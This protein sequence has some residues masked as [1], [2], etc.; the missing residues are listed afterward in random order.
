MC[1]FERA[2]VDASISADAGA[3]HDVP[4]R[5]VEHRLFFWV[6][7]LDFYIMGATHAPRPA[8]MDG[9]PNLD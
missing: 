7:L 5:R 4:Y 9:R 2:F 3:I 1:L 8:S 6:C